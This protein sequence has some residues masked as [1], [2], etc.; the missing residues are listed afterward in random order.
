MMR[1]LV[2]SL[3]NKKGIYMDEKTRNLIKIISVFVKEI[4]AFGIKF[5]SWILC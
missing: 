3:I 1:K 5:A 2:Y 4:V